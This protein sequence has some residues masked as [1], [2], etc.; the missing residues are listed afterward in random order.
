MT[1][2][3]PERLARVAAE[4]GFHA[5]SLERVARLIDLLRDLH[6]HPYLRPRLALKGGT[7]LNLFLFGLPRLSVDID[8]NYIGAG[9]RDKMLAERP[10]VEDAL[11]A[12]F[13]RQGLQVRRG[14]N[15]EHAGYKCH[16]GYTRAD[17]GRGQL[18]LD[19]NFLLRVPLWPPV[20]SR[21]CEVLGRAA[22]EI[23]LLD[24]HELAAGKL[25]AAFSRTKSRDL[26]DLDG[27]FRRGLD[28]ERLRVGFVVYGGA[29]RVDWRTITPDTLNTTAKD[30]SEQLLPMLR[31]DA[32]P[33][34]GA[35]EGWTRDLVARCRAHVGQLLPLRAGEREFLDLVCERGEVRPELLTAEAEIQARIAGHP[36]LLWKCLNVKKA[37]VGA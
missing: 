35:V 31:R 6:A 10:R 25:A 32:A 19:L 7:A 1:E 9:E 28:V 3:A 23:L 37:L 30:V 13:D 14:P 17:R 24:E 22:E 8:L 11:A 15:R 4:T 26:F 2:L 20:P 29:S 12:V 5:E 16:L 34:R 18:E 27:L 33:P 36:G 21:S